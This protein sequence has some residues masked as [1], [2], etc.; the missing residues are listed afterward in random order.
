[1]DEFNECARLQVAVWQFPDLDAVP[2]HLLRQAG[3]LGGVVL[4]AFDGETLAG[5]VFSLPAGDGY[6][7][8]LYAH[9]LGVHPAYRG[10]GIAEALIRHHV[11]AARQRGI[12]RFRWTYDPLVAVNANL[13]VRKLG[14]RVR[15]YK[16]DFYGTMAGINDG[17]PSDRFLVEWDLD[18]A[19]PAP[20]GGEATALNVMLLP[21]ADV[22]T[23]LEQALEAGLVAL[24]IPADFDTLRI[25]DPEAAREWRLRT[26]QAFQR[27]FESGGE[28]L[29]LINRGGHTFYALG[30]DA[31]RSEGPHCTTR[32]HTSGP[33]E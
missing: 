6:E 16:E 10:R 33:T 8:F 31:G 2:G 25:A 29:G 4:G 9:M 1:M 27:L 18:R 13:Y 32:Q 5:F 26:R 19:A 12:S 17:V 7:R 22:A 11:V 20:P 28:V 21:T 14:A 30:R 3:E 24:E 23:S 15:T